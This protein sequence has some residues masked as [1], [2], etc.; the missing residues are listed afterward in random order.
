MAEVLF[1]YKGIE[2]IIECNLNDKMEDIINEFISKNENAN[3]CLYFLDNG[4]KINEKLIFNQQAN[5][6]DNK[7]KKMNIL[8]YDVEKEKNNKIL[9]N[10]IKSKEVICPVC[11]ENIIISI[12]DYKINLSD[13]KNGHIINNMLFEEFEN[14]QKI[15]ISK[16]KCDKCKEKSIYDIYNN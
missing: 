9:E 4:D 2:T 7:R 8:V 1:N 15:N 10:I 14:N 12:K 3:K 16:I 6:I 13:C 5:E 11:N